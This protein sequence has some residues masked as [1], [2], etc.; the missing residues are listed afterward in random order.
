MT[1]TDCELIPEISP[2]YWQVIATKFAQKGMPGITYLKAEYSP[3]QWIETFVYRDECGNLLGIIDYFPVDTIPHE[4][5][6]NV[7][8]FVHPEHRGKGVGLALLKKGDER[9][10]IDFDKQQYTYSGLKL[11]KSY[12]RAIKK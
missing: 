4:K 11:V 9:W 7:N 12:Q 1:T 2:K 8:I 3:E 5:K 10:D 6:G